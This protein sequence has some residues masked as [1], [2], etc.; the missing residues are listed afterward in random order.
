[1]S[2]SMYDASIPPFVAML[3][4]LK[5]ILDKAEAYA[6]AKKIDPSVLVNARLACDMFPLSR[7][8]QIAADAVKGAGARLAGVEP[9]SHPDTETTLGELKARIDTVIAFVEGLDPA[10]FEGAEDRTITLKLG[11]NEVQ[12]PAKVFLFQFAIPNFYFHVTTT[13]AILRHNGLEV[14]KPDYLSALGS[15]M[16][17]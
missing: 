6:E 10:K 12:F 3:K 14:G 7:Q 16:G 5:T 2:L 9:P 8:V 13:Y 17:R 15:Y 1:M 11:P 4:S